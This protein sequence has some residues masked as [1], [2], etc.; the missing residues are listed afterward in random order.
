MRITSLSAPREDAATAREP[1]SST[2]RSARRYWAARLRAPGANGHETPAHDL[3]TVCRCSCAHNSS[4]EF[5]RCPG[6][7]RSDAARD[8]SS[9]RRRWRAKLFDGL[10]AVVQP[11]LAAADPAD[12]SGAAPVRARSTARATA[13]RSQKKLPPLRVLI[14]G[15]CAAS[16]PYC[17]RPKLGPRSAGLREQH[18]VA[19]PLTKWGFPT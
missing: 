7:G 11:Y 3:K 6:S 14:N 1:G 2:P 8:A 5:P 13:S 12:R 18:Q 4:G 9:T 16:D 19:G 17:G 15:G 10:R